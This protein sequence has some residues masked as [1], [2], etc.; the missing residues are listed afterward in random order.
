MKKHIP[1]RLNETMQNYKHFSFSFLAIVFGIVFSFLNFFGVQAKAGVPISKD[2]AETRIKYPIPELENCQ[3]KDACKQYCDLSSHYLV[4][5]DFGEKN[6]LISKE[7][8]TQSKKLIEVLKGKGPG[9][10]KD[11]AT[12]K[13]YCNKT[14]N[15]KECFIF[16]MKNG[17]ISTEKL[18]EMEDGIVKL[19]SGLK[20]MPLEMR[21]CIVEKSGADA[22][23]KIEGGKGE[24]IDLVEIGGVM[25]N[26]ATIFM[27]ELQ[28]NAGDGLKQAS[29]AAQG[30][31]KSMISSIGGKIKGGGSIDQSGIISVILQN[32]L[33]KGTK[34]PSGGGINMESLKYIEEFY[35]KSLSPKDLESL[36]KA[37]EQLK[38]IIP[39]GTE[40][41]SGKKSLDLEDVEKMQEEMQEDLEEQYKNMTPEELEQIKKS[42]EQQEDTAPPE[43][44]GGSSGMGM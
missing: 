26:C 10:C 16:S 4:C 40:I 2:T 28:K 43:I 23:N 21:S 17:L 31:V 6:D 8:A 32:C 7:E 19:R 3:N 30:C 25:Q 44:P 39:Q 1:I 37:R 33:P 34:I 38:G 13:N 24:A 11:E 29:P 35:G 9:G 5:T 27:G 42:Q 41:P 22:I 36:K 12:C 18:K 14:D 20:Q 15:Q